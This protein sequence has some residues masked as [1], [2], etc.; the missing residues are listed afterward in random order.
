M[1][2]GS[3]ESR[4]VY[5][6]I[7]VVLFV[8]LVVSSSFSGFVTAVPTAPAPAVVLTGD[9]NENAPALGEHWRVSQP[10]EPVVVDRPPGE[11]DPRVKLSRNEYP[12]LSGGPEERFLE[13]PYSGTPA[14]GPLHEH[15]NTALSLP[16]T[17]SCDPD[18]EVRAYD[19]SAIPVEIPLNRFGTHDPEGRMYV[20]TDN[21][22][23]VRE[24]EAVPRTDET[25][26]S[27]GLRD[28]P[29][30]PLVVRA[31]LGDCV[32]FT[33]R[34]ELEQPASIHVHRGLVTPDH[35]GSFV[36]EN[37]N[38]LVDPG[39]SRTYTLSIPADER[40]EGIW[41]F[42]SHG[43]AR[44]QTNHGLFG[45]LVV[46]HEGSEWFHPET[47]EP[48][49]SGWEAIVVDGQEGLAY[50]EYV[51]LYHEVGNETYQVR[52]ADG[53]K[54]PLIDPHTDAYRPCGFALN[55]RSECFYNRFE[56]QETTSHPRTA[57]TI[58]KS[59]AYSSYAFGDPATPI[60][61]AYVG[62]PS[63]VL[64]AH[65]GVEQFHSHHL[66]GGGIR[67]RFEPHADNHAGHEL[68]ERGLTKVAPGNDELS[69]SQRL[70]AQSIGP[71]E[72]YT[73]EIACGAGGCQR[74][75]GDFLFHC[76]VPEHYLSG[77]WAFWR[78]HNTLQSD[79][80][81]LPDREGDV[82]AAV[83]SA[84]LVGARLPSGD[85][86]ENASQVDAWVQSQLPPQGVPDGYD[87][88]V[89][90]WVRTETADGAPLYL[91]EPET[92]RGWENFRPVTPGERQPL[93][94]DPNTGRL[95]WPW[96]SP[97]LAQR[98]PFA[99]GAH[100]PAPYL[101]TPVAANDLPTNSDFTATP[102]DPQRPD[103]ALCPPGSRVQRF[104]IVAIQDG[105]AFNDHGDAIPD[106]MAYALAEHVPA[107]R[108]GDRP[109]EPLVYRGNV[110]DCIQVTLVSE[111]EDETA[112][113]FSKVNLHPHFVQFDVQA[114]DGAITGGAFEQSVRP[115][116][117]EPRETAAAV[118]AG[119]TVVPIE[120]RRPGDDPFEGLHEG[121]W[122]GIGLGTNDIELHRIERLDE[123]N[124]TVILA[125]PLV[126]DHPAESAFGVE[127]VRYAYYLDVNLGT[128]YFHD[129]VDAGLH[130]PRGLFGALI[131]EPSD[132]VY[133]HPVTGEEVRA[134]PIADIITG[135]RELHHRPTRS[136]REVVLQ[137][138]DA[139]DK[140]PLA[141]D[142]TG[143]I[144]L[145]AE[146]FGHRTETD[147]PDLAL[148]STVHG[149]P[150]T[151]LIRAYEGDAVFIHAQNAGTWGRFPIRV[152]GHRFQLEDI[153]GATAQDAVVVDFSE[154]FDLWLHSEENVRGGVGPAGD[155]LYY[156]PQANHFAD[157]MWGIMRVYGSEQP[158][159]LP[160]PENDP[161]D[162][163]DDL[164]REV[165]G[166]RPPAPTDAQA[167]SA[168]PADAPVHTFDVRAVEREITVDPVAGTTL[169]AKV[170]REVDAEGRLT[171]LV[172]HAAAGECVAVNLTNGLDER[173]SMHIGWGV[174]GPHSSGI[175]VG[176]NTDQ[177]VVPGDRRTYYSYV[178]EPG[179][180][181]L[182][183]FAQLD[184]DLEGQAA[185]LYGTIVVHEAG[186]RF[187]D[188]VTGNE[189][190]TGWGV[191]VVTDDELYRDYTLVFH[192]EDALFGGPVMPYPQHPDGLSMV[193]Y[194]A[195]ELSGNRA[196]DRFE[197]FEGTPTTPLLEAY[198]HDAVRINVIGGYGMQRG[199]FALHGHAWQRTPGIPES[200]AV[201]A[202]GYAPHVRFT[203]PLIDGA[204]PA[205]DYLWLNHR[206]PYA[207]MGQW[208]LLRVHGEETDL[209]P[210]AHFESFQEPP[211][212]P[213]PPDPPE[214]P[215][216]DP[217]EESE[218]PPA[219][220]PST[221]GGG[222]PPAS[223]VGVA[224]VSVTDVSLSVTE[225]TT[226]EPA[227]L[228]ATLENTGNASDR[229]EVRLFVDGAF[230]GESRIVEVP[231]GETVTV[232]FDF[233]FPPGEYTVGV[234]G[235]TAGTLTVLPARTPTP[236][237]SPTPVSTPAVTPDP[238]SP[239]TPTPTPEPTPPPAPIATETPV[240]D[241]PVGL[242]YA[243]VLLIVGLLAAM[244]VLLRR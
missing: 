135:E 238:D 37:E 28:D 205:G 147:P 51:I 33:L 150:S 192:E 9:A 172:I 243:V 128:V 222:A 176:Y 188:P 164:P 140:D 217:D 203:A 124:G 146:P 127:F 45:A 18:A 63:K 237:P 7:V 187:F 34:N 55:Y 36:G 46:E 40:F 54:I 106:A 125:E 24:Q 204:G 207:E 169:S 121:I 81:E 206:M 153:D 215:A 73:T 41:Y 65:A 190:D 216:D 1:T 3:G 145:R 196:P 141:G 92:T 148:S 72:T 50:R 211:E 68:I 212:A 80:A 91:K 88:T 86:L 244:V 157:G 174:T 113:G 234:E 49:D 171:P 199:V 242:S 26:V 178:D 77:M 17:R 48:L 236:E 114:S 64:V 6:Q 136:F 186:A 111:L 189:T 44:T 123:A 218:E 96:L 89:Y 120:P 132:A 240:P 70:D 202:M 155:Y 105:V 27:I 161:P 144:S 42:H 115:Y 201:S 100:G 149:D 99:P 223:P 142:V 213:E 180:G 133:R 25:R 182:A 84:D 137:F 118:S 98:P 156:N 38:S 85:R 229:F 104:N 47:M 160:L 226:E 173:V 184:D 126:R 66:H 56:L 233:A 151:P 143:T 130:W 198:P 138:S 221:G 224:N 14:L 4:R 21:I 232:T 139:P 8:A 152:T 159:L 52:E 175:T 107:I 82:A 129:H 23:A 5:L 117:T 53:G 168:C 241:I 58:D 209:L 170:F 90:D 191:V 227:T 167:R 43:N 235:L 19:V 93:T 112:G 230:A 94:F 39:D 134:G 179:T 228:T 12:E 162:A 59:L 183:D 20:L 29:I 231:A 57:G 225:T 60:P 193:N 10:V 131:V 35:D 69:A 109:F 15:L 208:G 76:H 185:G 97:H 219:P 2:S 220:Q 67:W 116:D 31:N 108:S 30:Q 62:D 200:S 74:A 110:G 163:G 13:V 83:T 158:D 181:I 87:A 102:E 103:D 194:R 210:L 61:R 95:A 78:V 177:S 122:V 16:D 239:A 22:D 71:G 195:T 166:A 101:T 75:V 79:L 214:P 32:E 165:T 119:D 11:F 154:R 197:S